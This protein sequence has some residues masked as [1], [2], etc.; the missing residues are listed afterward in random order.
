MALRATLRTTGGIVRWLRFPADAVLRLARTAGL[1]RRRDA[2]LRPGRRTARR[3]LRERVAGGPLLPLHR[4]GL[5]G[6]RGGARG[7]ARPRGG[8]R[9]PGRRA[10]VRRRALRRPGA[11]GP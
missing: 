8:A 9:R 7:R 3:G 10:A 6:G 11:Q 4:G 2:S 1:L 5:L